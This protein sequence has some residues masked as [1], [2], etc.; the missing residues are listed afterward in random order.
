[1]PAD[2]LAPGADTTVGHLLHISESIGELKGMLVTQNQ[3]TRDLIG[4][5]DAHDTRLGTLEKAQ[6]GHEQ[7]I[8]G[9][10][11]ARAA[12]AQTQATDH[13]S[14]QG[15]RRSVRLSTLASGLAFA[16][17]ALWK[18]WDAIGVHLLH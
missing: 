10:E 6:S 3:V 17:V 11:Q 15:F 4:R 2:P 9:I 18:L 14:Q 1:M 5:V 8:A 16:S 7:R 12:E 13:Q